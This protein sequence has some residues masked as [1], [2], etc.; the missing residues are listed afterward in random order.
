M[1][2]I[3]WAT[4]VMVALMFLGKLYAIAATIFA[5]CDESR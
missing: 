4:F 1:E 2:Y 5:A 3:Q